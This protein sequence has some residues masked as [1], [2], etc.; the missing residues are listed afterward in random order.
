MFGRHRVGFNKEILEKRVELEMEAAGFV[1]PEVEHRSLVACTFSHLKY[2]GR[3]P[4]THAVLRAFVGGALHEERLQQ[5]D[6]TMVAGVLADLRDLLGL[7]GEPLFARVH[8]WPKAMAQYVLGHGES[9]KVVRAREHIFPGFALVGNG[10]EGVG[11]PDIVAQADA[12]VDR[13]TG[14]TRDLPAPV[15]DAT[16]RATTA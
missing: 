3:A 2:G 9:V 14:R 15:R 12:A 5:D 10:Y 1:V 4:D 11:I 8:R 7:E 16:S 6:A 13:L